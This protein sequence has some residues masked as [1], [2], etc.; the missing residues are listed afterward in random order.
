[1]LN[2]IYQELISLT[3]IDLYCRDYFLENGQYMEISD[4]EKII[5][6][7]RQFGLY[8]EVCKKYPLEQ[9]LENIQAQSLAD[10]FYSEL[11]FFKENTD[12]YIFTSIRFFKMMS[13]VHHFFEIE[14]ILEGTAIYNP[15]TD[16]L[17]LKKGDIIIVPPEVEH[18]L[19][20]AGDSALVDIGIRR[21]T[22]ENAIRDILSSNFPIADYFSNMFY[23]NRSADCIV[24]R[25]AIDDPVRQLITLIYTE[26]KISD[27]I[28]GKMNDHLV[29]SLLCRIIQKSAAKRI[30]GIFEY[31]NEEMFRI[32]L[33]MVEHLNTVTLEM[34]GKQFHRSVS[35]IS[36]YIKVSTGVTYSR[37]LRDIRIECAKELLISTSLSITEIAHEVGY[38]CD[39]YFIDIFRRIC[40]TTPLQYRKERTKEKQKAK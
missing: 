33:Y 17:E 10:I 8:E 36:R 1:M 11:F 29:L 23:G 14:C 24:I 2:E 5:L 4:A 30:F 35:G 37:L 39:S 26:S 31:R 12:I 3:P 38:K 25:N 20:A 9:I 19:Q 21:S 13:H 32:R 6:F 28:S 7:L 27:E 34:L 16:H 18:N 40:K 15:D 22:F